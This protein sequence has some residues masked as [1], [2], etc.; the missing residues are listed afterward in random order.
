MGF[1]DNMAADKEDISGAEGIAHILKLIIN[2]ALKVDDYLIEV[3]IM[4]V[5]LLAGS[6]AQ[7]ENMIVLK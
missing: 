7:V 6:I 5:S 2:P 3:V 1:M 4:V